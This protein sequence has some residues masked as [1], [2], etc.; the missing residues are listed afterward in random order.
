MRYIFRVSQPSLSWP[1]EPVKTSFATVELTPDIDGGGVTLMIDGMESSHHNFADPTVLTFEYMQ[2]L[3]AVLRAEV[4]GGGRGTA[5]RG[6]PRVLHVGAAGCTMARAINAEWPASH[7]VAIEIDELLATYVREWFDLPRSPQLRIRVQDGAEAVHAAPEGRY[8]VVIRDAFSD[9]RAPHRLT[10]IEFTR[11]VHRVLSPGGLYLANSANR[12]P[13][14][15][16]RR[17]AAT[18]G[19]VFAHVSVILEPGV[20]RGRRYGNAVIVG[21]SA[22]LDPS[23]HRVLRTL[24]APARLLDGED[25]SRFVAGHGYLT[26]EELSAQTSPRS[27]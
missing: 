24:P 22:P 11:H 14:T 1:T 15:L 9:R 5:A 23:L 12:P 21:S 20:L 8:E 4:P 26:E 17:E 7:Q 27:C 18:V 13:L 6:R 25:L 3:Q 16:T 2:Y 10:T 19:E